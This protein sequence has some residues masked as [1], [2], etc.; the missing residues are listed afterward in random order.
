M[1]DQL[2]CKKNVTWAP[3]RVMGPKDRGRES[4]S[5]PSLRTGQALF[6]HPALQ[7]M[8]SSSETEDCE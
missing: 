5:S 3:V 4:V 1:V 8:G 7:L 6:A 2:L